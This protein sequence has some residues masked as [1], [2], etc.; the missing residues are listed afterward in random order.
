LNLITSSEQ[1][2]ISEEQPAQTSALNDI[3]ADMFLAALIFE[4]IAENTKIEQTQE[5]YLPTA[6][7][8]PHLHFANMVDLVAAAKPVTFRK[9]T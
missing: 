5:H 6:V 4:D 1:T 7:P 2:N 3:L 8:L 9:P